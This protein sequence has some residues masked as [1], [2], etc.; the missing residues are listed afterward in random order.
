MHEDDF[1]P[2]GRE[3]V[4]FHVLVAEAQ[5]AA[6]GAVERHLPDLVRPGLAAQEGEAVAVGGEGR[7]GLVVR[8]GG[9]QCVFC[10]VRVHQV[11]DGVALV[12]FHAVVAHRVGDFP[13]VG[14]HGEA[15]NPSHGP[16]GF[17][18]EQVAREGDLVFPD[19]FLPVVGTRRGR[20][21]SQSQGCGH[22]LYQVH[23]VR[24]IK[25]IIPALRKGSRPE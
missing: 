12:L 11:D 22:Y 17:G 9:E 15:A 25:K 23:V 14:R 20:G 3:L 5:L 24:I 16:E 4:S 19:D 18:G 1:L 8:S 6:R 7:V 21:G 10:P 13:C 2:V